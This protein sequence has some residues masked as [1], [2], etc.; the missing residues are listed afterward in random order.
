MIP[1]CSFTGQHASGDCRGPRR[2]HQRL[3]RHPNPFPEHV[4]V[5]LLEE[6]A[7]KRRQSLL[8]LVIVIVLRVLPSPERTHSDD[9]RWPS[10]LS[11]PAA[12]PNFHHVRDSNAGRNR[13]SM[14]QEVRAVLEQ[15]VGDRQALF[16]E[17]EQSWTRRDAARRLYAAA[18]SGFSRGGS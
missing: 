3:G 9:A 14:E 17:I 4:A 10:A 13:Q 8:D 15:H 16:D 5:L 11:T 7:N 2:L 12:S 1:A 18:S 6:L